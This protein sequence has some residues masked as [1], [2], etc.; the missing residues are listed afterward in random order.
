M[1]SFLINN[2]IFILI[3]LISLIYA[4]LLSFKSVFK[5]KNLYLYVEF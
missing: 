5:I 2:K 4:I 1:L 3:K